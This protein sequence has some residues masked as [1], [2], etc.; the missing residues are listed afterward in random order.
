MKHYLKYSKKEK[1]KSKGDQELIQILK[2]EGIKNIKEA[3]G[4]DT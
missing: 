2:T 4:K 3:I 1:S